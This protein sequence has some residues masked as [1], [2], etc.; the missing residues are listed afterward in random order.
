MECEKVSIK[1]SFS[2]TP[3]EHRALQQA[4]QTSGLQSQSKFL[5][6]LVRQ[7]LG[8]Y[9]INSFSTTT[10]EQGND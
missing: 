2:I 9:F 4:L 7:S 5:R 3:S 6:R 1:L 8:E 10:G